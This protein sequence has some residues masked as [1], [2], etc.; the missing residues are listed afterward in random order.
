MTAR[1]GPLGPEQRKALA[2]HLESVLEAD[3]VERLK[4]QLTSARH[5]RNAARDQAAAAQAQV[6]DLREA[7]RRI[8]AI[9]GWSAGDPAEAIR[10]AARVAADALEERRPRG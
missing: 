1:L 4:K 9:D 10:V 5:E 8:V 7:L 2:K 6:A 3:R